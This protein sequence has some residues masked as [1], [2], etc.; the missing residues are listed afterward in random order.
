MRNAL[1]LTLL[2]A[3][4]AEASPPPAAA[5]APLPLE[6]PPAE[7]VHAPAVE[8]E[9]PPGPPTREVSV[10]EVDVEVLSTGREPRASLLGDEPENA[11]V[12]VAMK[13][14]SRVSVRL[15]GRSTPNAL[16]VHGV[17]VLAT[18]GR[19]RD[20]LLRIEQTSESWE[21][22]GPSS[23]QGLVSVAIR[24][25]MHV[26]WSRA[27]DGRVRS[28][29]YEVPSDLTGDSLERLHNMV[30]QS[31]GANCNVVPD[32]PLGVGA[33]W[34]V[35]ERE[36]PDHPVTCTLTARVGEAVTITNELTYDGSLCDAA[37]E[38]ATLTRDRVHK[39]VRARMTYVPG[40][41]A[42]G[43]SMTEID[44]TTR[45][46]AKRAGWS[47]PY[48]AVEHDRVDVYVVD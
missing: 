36:D 40:D 5:P 9:A 30:E 45:G 47:A 14:R 25:R 19:D 33:R 21:Q 42:R 3:G 18:H 28:A 10:P 26:W 16:D 46:V 1:A 32:V 12:R 24:R 39:V 31:F 22:G 6:A 35:R 44:T 48:E 2:L 15:R 41:V 4:C 37:A 23:E 20:G 34:R 27:R 29:R 11:R 13:L 38:R 8:E 7:L 17:V 43:S